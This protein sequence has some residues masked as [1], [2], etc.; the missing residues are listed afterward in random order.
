MCT[1]F[2]IVY[3]IT[4]IVC[5]INTLWKVKHITDTTFTFCC[6]LTLL[7]HHIFRHE[8]VYKL[9]R[10]IIFCVFWDWLFLFCKLFLTE[11]FRNVLFGKLLRSYSK[12]YTEKVA[13]VYPIG[14]FYCKNKNFVTPLLLSFNYVLGL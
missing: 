12:C 8:V 7:K 2:I 6:K 9:T 1:K 3:V 13:K 10:S 5:A 14:L 11:K 4:Q